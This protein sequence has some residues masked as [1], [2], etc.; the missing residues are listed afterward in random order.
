MEDS[1][2]SYLGSLGESV[3]LRNLPVLGNPSYLARFPSPTG[4]SQFSIGQA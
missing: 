1:M 4:S 3:Y 2:V